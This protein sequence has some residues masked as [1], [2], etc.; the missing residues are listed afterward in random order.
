ME[1]ISA[2]LT[3]CAGNPPVTGEF[4]SQRPVTRRFD[5]FF[6]LRRNK[7]WV[8]YRKAGDV[9]LHRSHYDGIEHYDCNEQH[10]TTP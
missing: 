1:K 7:N 2:L 9:R 5:V 10:E 6:D 3:F 8:N 4:P